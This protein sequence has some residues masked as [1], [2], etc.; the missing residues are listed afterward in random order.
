MFS[1]NSNWLEECAP[2]RSNKELLD[3]FRR[4]F[5]WNSLVEPLATR[6]CARKY[7]DYY[8]TIDETE[9]SSFEFP[10]EKNRPKVL[11]C[12]DVSDP[13]NFHFLSNNDPIQMKNLLYFSIARRLTYLKMAGNY[14]QDR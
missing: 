11:V 10:D 1:E 12:H 4:P 13:N 8:M 14:L 2:I 7:G 3:Y 5:S 9:N 6:C